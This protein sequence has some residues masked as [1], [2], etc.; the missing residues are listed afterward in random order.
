MIDSEQTCSFS[1]ATDLKVA[2][3]PSG[4]WATLVTGTMGDHCAKAQEA[5]HIASNRLKRKRSIGQ[6]PGK[7]ERIPRTNRISSPNR[8]AGNA[9]MTSLTCGEDCKNNT[10]LCPREAR[11][12]KNPPA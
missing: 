4:S 6:P 11:V 9:R 10:S 8:M 2:R 1:T 7:Q 5:E 12:P 3:K